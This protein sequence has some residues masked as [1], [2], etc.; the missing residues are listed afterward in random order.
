MFALSQGPSL[1]TVRDR[2]TN[3]SKIRDVKSDAGRARSASRKPVRAQ[4][5]RVEHHHAHMASSFF[6]SP[7][8]QAALLSI[9]GFGDF[10]S[11]M[12]GKG[13]GNKIESAAGSSFRTRW[14]CSIPR[15][16]STSASRNTATSSR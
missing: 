2:L 12:W 9:D 3:V 14:A 7:F 5:H 10:V 16:R 4:V 6:V 15:S 13:C 11:T 1:A 8:E